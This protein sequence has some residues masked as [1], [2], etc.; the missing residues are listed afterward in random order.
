MNES[1][2]SENFVTNF[3]KGVGNTITAAVK[4]TPAQDAFVYNPEKVKTNIEKQ[5]AFV[6]P[7]NII[8]ILRSRKP[9]NVIAP[10]I[11]T[12]IIPNQMLDEARQYYA[13]TQ[14]IDD[15][16]YNSRALIGI[17]ERQTNIRK[18]E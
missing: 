15:L 9:L 11:D 18:C 13:L 4:P 7:P 12:N 17:R 10:S 5:E 1:Q 8:K 14:D 6:E 3:V 2:H 16:E